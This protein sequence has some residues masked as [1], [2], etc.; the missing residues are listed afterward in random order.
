M[1]GRNTK[2]TEELIDRICEALRAGNYIETACAFAGIAPATY[3]R[4]VAESEQ[5]DASELLV[6]FRE[7]VKRARA[8]A[9]VR[10]VALIQ[11]AAQDPNKWQASAW[12]L[13]RSFPARWGRQQKIT[14]EIT[15]A[16][17]GPIEVS[18]VRA[19]LLSF[20]EGQKPEDEIA[21]E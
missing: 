18:D 10:N 2:L 12:W 14:Q 6:E 20:L 19:Q 11:K 13:E 1:S 5:D 8:D 9:E 4:W 21:S 16:N 7:A 15:G 17:G 3:Y